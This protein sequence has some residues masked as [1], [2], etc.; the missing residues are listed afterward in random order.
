MRIRWS[1]AALLLCLV[2]LLPGFAH[3][4]ELVYTT[5]KVYAKDG[6]TPLAGAIVAVYDDKNH[7]VDYTRTDAYGEYTLAVPRSA[8]HLNKKGGGGFLHQ[9]VSGVS[10]VV[11]GAARMMAYPLRAGIRVAQDAANAGDPLTKLG[12]GAAGGIANLLVDN[13]SP[14]EKSRAQQARSLPGVLVVKATMPGCND[15]VSLARVYWVEEQNFVLD[16]KAKR[17]LA[18]W[19]DPVQM[20]PAGDEKPSTISSDYL[21]FTEARL[22]PSIAEPGQ[23]VQIIAK[24]PDPPAPRTPCIVVARN[25][26]T[27]RT[28]EL[29]PEGGGYYRGELRVDKK[30]PRNDQAL[31]IVA[32][33]DQDDKPGRNKKAEDAIKKAGLFD[34]NKPYVYD[35]LLV[36]S[37]N[38]AEVTLTVVEPHRR[39]RR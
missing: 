7:V 34:P 11:S 14:R 19:V 18:A 6:K 27:G 8:L 30:N 10:S 12:V 16:G 13:M 32:Y 38:R 29:R 28:F 23:V 5:G 4:D 21:T 17:G 1:L 31:T 24:L 15:A 2:C 20:T 25:H 3:A 35:P 33:A 39:E 22:E 26:R 9:V 36:V 37:R